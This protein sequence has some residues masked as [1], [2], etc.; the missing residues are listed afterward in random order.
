M[1]EPS[2]TPRFEYRGPLLTLA[3][4][5]QLLAARR[6]QREHIEC[7]LDLERSRTRVAISEVDWEWSGARYPYLESCKDRTIY[8]WEG[9]AFRPIS[10]YATSLIKLVPTQWGAPTFEIDGIKMLPTAHVSPY[11]DAQRKVALIEPRGKDV[12]D[13]C[14]GLGYFAAWCLQG[15]ARSVRS[16]EKNPDGLW[17]RSLN[18]WS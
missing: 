6:E 16:F 12:L 15:G 4:H 17:V 14:G 7:S 5:D 11:E 18:P 10:R 3:I 2:S 1:S 13:T 8:F 9:G